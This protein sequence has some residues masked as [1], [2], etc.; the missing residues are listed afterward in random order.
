[1]ANYVSKKTF[2][3]AVFK[4]DSGAEL[5]LI[6]F[7]YET[8]G[9]LNKRRDN[10][11]LIS[12]YLSGTSHAAGLYSANDSE[13]GYWQA[14]IGPGK[15]IDT[16]RFFVVA[17]DSLCCF[18]ANDTRVVTTGPKSIAPS[19]GK[20]Y[21]LRFPVITIGDQVE[22]QKRLADSLG[23]EKWFAVAGPSMGAMQSCEW[24]ARYP[25]RVE[26]VIAAILPGLSCEAY[27]IARLS[28]WCAPI[29]LDPKFKGGDYYEDEEPIEGL[30]Q[31]IL[32]MT[33]DAVHFDGMQR[34]FQRRWA[35]RSKSPGVNLKNRFSIERALDGSSYLRA[36][37]CD[38][39]SL[40]YLTRSAQ[41]YNIED[42]L[43]RLRARFL[44]I[45]ASSDL[46]M[47]PGMTKK[48][49]LLLKERGI[50]VSTFTIEGD[51]GH[52]DGLTAIGKASEAIRSFLN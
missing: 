49:E 3:S 35:D 1:M 47:P 22:A 10:A 28:Q 9:E 46:V 19:T 8:Y 12:H 50:D 21:G 27:L 38:A 42:R 20:P 39:N 2:E 40:L 36:P 25:E 23:V 37:L 14:I 45:P 30:T 26:R 13:P 33:L 6:K 48:M 16:D 51:G 31:S 5:P 15:A 29:R 17:T 41:L 44:L 24:A 4:F 34:L 52:F 18:A 43:D 32:F 7:G 11:I